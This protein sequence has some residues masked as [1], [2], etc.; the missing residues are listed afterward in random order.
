MAAPLLS[1]TGQTFYKTD[2]VFTNLGFEGRGGGREGAVH[3]SSNPKGEE[4]RRQPI[5]TRIR[6]LR[7]TPGRVSGEDP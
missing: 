2:M 5:M 3:R 1:H 7:S 6:Q 4:D